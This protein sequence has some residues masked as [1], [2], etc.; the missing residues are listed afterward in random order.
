MSQDEI[1]LELS[2]GYADISAE[3][4]DGCLDHGNP[5]LSHRFL[6]VLE[7]SHSAEPATGWVPLPLLVDEAAVPL[8]L[9][10]HSYG[11][12]MFD[13]N[14][15][16]AYERAGGSYY[17]KLQVA[18]PFSPIPGPRILTRQG[19]EPAATAL[20][21]L[22]SKLRCSSVHLTFCTAEESQALQ[23]E[24][25][26]ERLGLQFHW[27]NRGYATFDDFL[28]ELRS[29]KR[30][31]IKR[32]RRDALKGLTLDILTGSGLKEAHWDEFYPLY[33]STYDRKWGSPQLTREFF[34]LL[35]ERMADEV[36]LFLARQGGRA[37]AGAFNLKGRDA[38]YG[39]NWGCAG[40]F[41]FLHF[42]CCYYQAIDFAI[43]HKLSRVEAGVQ[44]PHKLPRGYL[45]VLTYGASWFPQQI[46][47]EVLGRHLERENR[48]TR[49]QVEQLTAMGPYRA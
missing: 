4:W 48:Q 33:T 25:F 3:R 1:R 46:F 19:I 15:A 38:L 44:G 47:Q 13:W 5:F 9:K 31:T 35:T 23:K 12:F 39:R 2:H 26:M 49:R 7:E 27:P 17:P 16:E 32:E 45:P 20:K 11:E 24:G 8:Y 30:K 34:S 37:V 41:P 43:A 18:V 10:T 42:E 21:A 22:T 40:D 6:K 29:D 28:A 36:V 14:W